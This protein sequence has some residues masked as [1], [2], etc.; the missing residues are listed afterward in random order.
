[1]NGAD[2]AGGEPDR[3]DHVAWH[4]VI[5]RVEGRLTD[6]EITGMHIDMIEFAGKSQER[7]VAFP[8]HCVD[9]RPRTLDHV[10]DVDRTAR[11]QGLAFIIVKVGKMQDAGAIRWG[12]GA[13]DLVD[14]WA[15]LLGEAMPEG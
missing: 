15:A 2:V 7:V 12:H 5:G 10:F 8:P 4:L 13:V 14:W 1:M 9:N 11:G 6:L 3:V